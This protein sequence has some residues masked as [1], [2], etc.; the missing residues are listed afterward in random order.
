VGPGYEVV[1]GAVGRPSLALPPAA[2]GACSTA[3]GRAWWPVILDISVGGTDVRRITGH[4]GGCSALVGGGRPTNHGE[5]ASSME[6][7]R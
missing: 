7:S 5:T 4:I 2:R 6:L 1:L 3:G